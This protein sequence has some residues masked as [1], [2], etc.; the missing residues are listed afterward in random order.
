MS[1]LY[2]ATIPVFIHGLENIRSWLKKSERHAE[3]TGIP[4]KQLLEARLAPDMFDLTHQIGYAYFTSLEAA[5]N[6]SGKPSPDM[7]YD[8]KNAAELYAS[9]E[10]VVRHLGSIQP[11]DIDDSASRE[12]ETFLVPSRVRLDRY[13]HHFCLPNFYFHIVTAYG[14]LR[15]KGVPLGKAD[16]IGTPPG[17]KATR[18]NPG[19]PGE[20]CPP[21]APGAPRSPAA[22]RCRRD[23]C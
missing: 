4:M 8:E 6:L 13:V 14:I 19:S 15:H 9:I 21:C 23:P 10:Q 11:G 18:P 3:D 7:G 1:T 22:P 12:V 16:Y 17:G 2:D 20:R 5:A